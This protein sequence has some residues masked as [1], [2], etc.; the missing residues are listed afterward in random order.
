V[1]RLLIEQTNSEAAL[2]DSEQKF[3]SLYEMTS[4]AVMLM[5]EQGFLDCNSATL[6]ILGCTHKSQIIG[7]QPINFAPEFQPDGTASAIAANQHI[8]TTYQQGSHRFEWLT[9]PL[10]GPL[11][12]TEVL[13]T[14][15]DF[16]SYQLLQCVVRDITK[17]KQVES[18]LRERAAQLRT[19]NQVLNR[20]TKHAAVTQGILEFATQ[21]IT[22]A[23]ATTLDVERV[24][25]WL[26]DRSKIRLDCIE[27]YQ[28][29]VDTHS[30]GIQLYATDYPNYFKALE[31]G[32][33]I[34][35]SQ[36]LLDPQTL[37]FGEHYFKPLNIV[38]MLDC[39]IRM[40]GDV[41]GILCVEQVQDIREWSPEDESF[42]RAIADITALAI[43]ARDRRLADQTLQQK[44]QELQ[45]TLAELRRTQTQMVQT[46]K[47]SSLGQLVAGVA[48]EINNPVNF[49]HGNI[50]HAEGYTQDLLYLIELYQQAYPQPAEEIAETIDAIDL[51]FLQ[52]DL[53]KLLTSMRSG[54]ERIREIVKSL[55]NFSRLDES[56]LKTV[57]LHEGLDSTLMILQNR[58][59]AKPDQKGIQ[60]IRDYG[61]LPEIECYPGQLNQVF[62][63]LLLNAIDALELEQEEQLALF[64]AHC[65]T[66]SIRICTAALNESWVVIRIIDNGPGIPEAIRDRLFDP[67]FTTKPI[68]K[69]TGL[70]LSIS[71]QIV[72][73]KHGGSLHYQPASDQGTE[74]VIQLPIQPNLQELPPQIS[75]SDSR[76]G[77]G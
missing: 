59:K 14:P 44:Q 16:G 54:S 29:S 1:R 64:A 73:E 38:S 24:S 5:G 68:G 52:Q 72:T 48:H 12:F 41:V 11:F 33:S 21:A 30:Q 45:Q 77:V 47:M 71:Y 37:E 69:G 55:R 39:P 75:S 40:A 26:Y 27:L 57:D 13:L 3:R 76:E 63:N 65:T 23:T 53:P 4:D 15:I 70:G 8:Q 67:F 74:F 60:V 61:K 6:N 32:E 34:A 31:Q 17:Q 9:R 46:E 10:D 18:A 2:R 22:E 28:L 51:E 43:E 50:N 58:L 20:L 25:I 49:I 42:T 36:V 19:Q 62:M 35:A 56:E 7:K 66:P